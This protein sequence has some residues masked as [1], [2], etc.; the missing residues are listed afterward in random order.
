MVLQNGSNILNDKELI[1]IYD[2][3]RPIGKSLIMIKFLIESGDKDAEGNHFWTGSTQE[4]ARILGNQ[5]GDSVDSSNFR[6]T[7]IQP[8]LDRKVVIKEKIRRKTT[9]YILP[10]DW[11]LKVFS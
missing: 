9:R 1:L 11:K 6:H 2:K 7:V 4:L 5:R 3:L 10:T 8:L